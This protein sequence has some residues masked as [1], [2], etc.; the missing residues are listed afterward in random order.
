MTNQELLI[1]L[2]KKW[3]DYRTSLIERYGT[4]GRMEATI[5]D[6]SFFLNDLRSLLEK[7]K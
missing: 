4:Q 6:I 7:Q 5:D 1:A 3:Q 2:I